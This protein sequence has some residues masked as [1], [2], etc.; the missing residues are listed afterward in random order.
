M[1]IQCPCTRQSCHQVQEKQGKI[2]KTF[3]Y[4]NTTVETPN[5]LPFRK[6]SQY[7]EVVC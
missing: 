6:V 7:Y 5:T 2:K 1:M 3:T 4:H